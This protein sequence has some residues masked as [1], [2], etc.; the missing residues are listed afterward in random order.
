MIIINLFSERTSKPEFFNK[1]YL[2]K[3]KNNITFVNS[4]LEKLKDDNN[5]KFIKAWGFAKE[6]NKDY[7]SVINK[8]SF[9]TNTY[10]IGIKEKAAK[11]NHHPCSSNW[12]AIGGIESAEITP[13]LDA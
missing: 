13:E 5:N 1:N 6:K 3:N 11:Q 9:P 10:I 12:S 4:L 7:L 8:I 2:E